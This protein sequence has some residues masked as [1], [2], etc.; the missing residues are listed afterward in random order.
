MSAIRATIARGAK[1]ACARTLLRRIICWHVSTSA[2]HVALTFDDGPD[3]EGTP[4]VLEILAA[5]D[6][7]ATFFLQG[8]HAENHSDIV[9]RIV[10]AGHDVGNH[11]YDHA[12][13]QSATQAAQCDA[14][15]K[16]QGVRTRLFRPPGGVL[17]VQDL[18]W[19]TRSGYT[20][21]MWSF[22]AVDS[23]R[24][25]GKWR[26]AAPEYSGIVAGDIV[27]MHDDNAACLRDLPVLLEIMKRKG[28]QPVTLSRLIGL[29]GQISPD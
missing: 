14:A 2:P 3:E 21:V 4:A 13:G 7:P 5:H 8:N 6:A 9:R 22:D 23:M 17:S 20:T 18:F 19:L 15:L 24:E 11:G 10:G 25:E 28:L 26:G 1:G 12:R 16:R 29:R 27:L